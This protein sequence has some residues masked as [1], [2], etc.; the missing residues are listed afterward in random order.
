MKTIKQQKP[1]KYIFQ[2]FE[3]LIILIINKLK[4]LEKLWENN[5]KLLTLLHPQL[6]ILDVTFKS[7]TLKRILI[8]IHSFSIAGTFYLLKKTL[9][10]T[11]RE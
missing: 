10:Q 8:L 11:Q 9:T 2:N 7:S 3:I 5:C 1:S 4:N 6:K